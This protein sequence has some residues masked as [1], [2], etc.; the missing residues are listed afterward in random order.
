MVHYTN[1]MF[2]VFSFRKTINPRDLY[3]RRRHMIQKI[4]YTT[5]L[6]ECERKVSSAKAT[7]MK[8]ALAAKVRM[9]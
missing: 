8:E 3:Y 1:S 2:N 4:A 7:E 6:V 5:V 9:N